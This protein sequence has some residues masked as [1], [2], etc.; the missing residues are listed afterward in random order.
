MEN[1]NDLGVSAK[2]R[3]ANKNPEVFTKTNKKIIEGDV[4]LTSSKLYDIAGKIIKVSLYGPDNYRSAV[5]SHYIHSKDKK[6]R[7]T[8][9]EYVKEILEG[10][11]ED[12]I[13]NQVAEEA[14]QF[15]FKFNDVIFPK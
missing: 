2:K 6:L 12:K 1:Y 13:S 3:S 5:I 11:T 8:A 15:L 14:I 7:K 9:I 4:V 10:Y